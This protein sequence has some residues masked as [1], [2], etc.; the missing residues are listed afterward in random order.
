MVVWD[1]SNQCTTHAAASAVPR[2]DMLVWMYA[3]VA[4]A[5]ESA[6]TLN[7]DAARMI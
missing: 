5:F 1:V 3:D 2:I 4:L 6:C 7:R